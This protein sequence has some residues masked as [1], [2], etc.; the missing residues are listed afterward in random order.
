MAENNLK[1]IFLL[2]TQTINYKTVIMRLN[3]ARFGIMRFV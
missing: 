2:R 3:A 1:A